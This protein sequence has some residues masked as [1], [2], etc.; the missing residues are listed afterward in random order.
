LGKE[1]R[2][3]KIPPKQKQLPGKFS[4]LVFWLPFLKVIGL[5][6]VKSLEFLDSLEQPRRG[7]FC[8]LF[9]LQLWVK[10]AQVIFSLL[11]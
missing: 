7:K 6:A 9:C 8:W 11:I 1:T 5:H 2:D 3:P 10:F 4:A